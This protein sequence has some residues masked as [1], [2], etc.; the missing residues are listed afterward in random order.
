MYVVLKMDI[1]LPPPPCP[2]IPTHTKKKKKCSSQDLYTSQWL[3]WG[4]GGGIIQLPMKV[5]VQT[6]LEGRQHIK[7]LHH[8]FTMH[9]TARLHLQKVI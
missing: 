6:A 2:P 1:N 9:I 4:G 8:K 3:K 5:S 7:C